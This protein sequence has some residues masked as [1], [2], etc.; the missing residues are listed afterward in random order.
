MASRDPHWRCWIEFATRVILRS[1]CRF[2]EEAT[3]DRAILLDHTQRPRNHDF[4]REEAGLPYKIIPVNVSTAHQFKPELLAISPNN[5]IPVV[6]NK[7]KS[8]LGVVAPP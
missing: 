4:S 6:D 2:S 3:D 1:R 7:P 5:R 8:A